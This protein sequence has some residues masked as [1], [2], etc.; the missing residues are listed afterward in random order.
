MY[1]RSIIIRK[2]GGFYQVFDNDALIISYLFNYKITNHKCGF[3]IIAINKIMNVLEEKN[4]NYIIK[5]EEEIVK[6]FR[7]KNTYSMYLEKSKIKD[8]INNRVKNILDKLDKL[9]SKKLDKTLSIIEDYLY[10]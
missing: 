8:N 10:E 6:N 5:D 7:C 1:N 9:D 3:P 2:S 4:I